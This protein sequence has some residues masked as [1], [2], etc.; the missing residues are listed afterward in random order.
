VR[1]QYVSL[2]DAMVAASAPSDTS[3]SRA[4]GASL[5][6]AS[7]AATSLRT[8]A[9]GGQMARVE[10]RQHMLAGLRATSLE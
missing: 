6:E 1:Q 2:A 10:Q 9:A 5:G 4:I 7:A 8:A 3:I